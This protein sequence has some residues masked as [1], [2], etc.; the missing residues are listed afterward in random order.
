VSTCAGWRR[1]ILRDK[2]YF[3]HRDSPI[4]N[5]SQVI[6]LLPADEAAEIN[7]KLKN[8]DKE[9]ALLSKILTRTLLSE[10]TEGNPLSLRF[11]KG[12]YGKPYLP[13]YPHVHYNLSH[14]GNILCLVIADSEIGVDIEKEKEIED[15]VMQFSCSQEEYDQLK[16]FIPESRISSFFKIWCLKESFLKAIGTGL[17]RELKSFS[18]MEDEARQMRLRDYEDSKN[19]DK[20]IFHYERIK[21]DYHFSLCYSKNEGNIEKEWIKQK[22]LISRFIYTS[23]E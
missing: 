13:Q 14:A 16:S 17:Y 23:F 9:M 5:F 18:I 7:K 15:A 19:D 20:W 8:T 1:T 3:V 21:R 4:E 22:D 6:N 11:N 2:V 10:Y 12:K